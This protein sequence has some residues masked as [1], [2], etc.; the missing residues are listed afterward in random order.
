M[1]LNTLWVGKSLPPLQRLCLASAVGTGARVRLFTYEPVEGIPPGVEVVD[2]KEVLGL[3]KMVRHRKSQSVALF[4]DRFRY[5]VLAKGLGAWFD[6]DMLFLK[7]PYSTGD[8]LVGWEEP[9]RVS[10]GFIWVTPGHPLINDLRQHAFD[11]HPIPGWYPLWRRSYLSIRKAVGLPQHVSDAD[12]GV[13]GPYLL[14]WLLQKHKMTSEIRPVSWSCGLPWQE[15]RTIW[16]GSY[17]WRKWVNPDTVCVHLWNHG[18][19]REE[20]ARKPEPGSLLQT[21]ADG[22]GFAWPEADEGAL[23]GEANCQ[24]NNL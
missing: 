24:P 18:L 13:I 4:S 21:V 3:D 9:E 16:D 11:E 10:A 5:E 12:W 15:R 8:Y 20:R 6:T 17:D 1:D 7:A 2:G 19:T 14:T 23:K 22:S